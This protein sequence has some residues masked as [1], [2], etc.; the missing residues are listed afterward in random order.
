MR[1]AGQTRAD[2][3]ALRALISN[4]V[5]TVTGK[6]DDLESS[7]SPVATS[8]DYADLTGKPT[9]PTV[10][11]VVSAFANDAGYL[12]AHQDLTPVEVAVTDSGYVTF[13]PLKVW[14]SGNVVTVYAVFTIPSTAPTTS[15]VIATGLPKPMHQLKAVA[16][17]WASTYSRTVVLT[18]ETSG[19]LKAVYGKASSKYAIVFSYVT[20]ESA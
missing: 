11:T 1:S 13:D 12:T 19:N 15:Q 2:L 18:L 20:S 14:R 5:S 16:S 6:I 4:G 9:I 17:S 3:M 7:L 8:G 10:P